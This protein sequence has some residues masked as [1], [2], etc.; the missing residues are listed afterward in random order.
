VKVIIVDDEQLARASLRSLLEDYCPQLE[1]AGEAASVPE[2][3]K[4]IMQVRPKLVFLDIE[5]PGFSG[6]KLLDFFK[7]EEVFFHIIFVTAY[8]QYAVDA[9]RLSAVDYLLKPIEVEQLQEA[10]QKLE[11][12]P[13]PNKDTAQKISLLQQQLSNDNLPSRIA[14]PTS[15]GVELFKPTD[16]RF[17]Q[18]DGSYAHIYFTNGEKMMVSKKL[19]EFDVLETLATFFRPHRSYIINLEEVQKYVRSDG[20]YI[21]MNG[22]EQ[23]PISKPRKSEFINLINNML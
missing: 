8:A 7:P 4:L 21:I 19:G 15:D 17:I 20:G 12:L 2:A 3:I 6:L 22:G 18:A 13:L 10:V 9:F 14:I 5:M 23:I 11:N 1:I 16:I